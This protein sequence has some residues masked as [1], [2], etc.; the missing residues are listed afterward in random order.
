MKSCLLSISIL[1]L[2]A[3]P[4]SAKVWRGI[5]PL[6]STRAD[7]E[8]LFG[9]PADDE[10]PYMWVYDFP[11]ERALIYF[12]SG[13]PCEEGLAE[14]W[15]VPKDIVVQI[16]TMPRSLPKLSEMLTPGKEYQ[17]IRAVHTPTVYYVDSE[18]G[19]SFT[20]ADD[21]VQSITYGA[22]AKDK[23]LSCGEYKYA[24]PVAAGAKLSSI[25][26]YPFDDFGNIRFDDAKARLDNFVIQLFALKEEE[27]RWQGYII[28]YAGRRSYIGAAQYKANCF[29]NY[30]APE[31]YK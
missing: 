27:P 12:S 18:E 30:L 11:E 13:Q 29:K 9:H 1:L 7:V 19:L 21:L 14:G 8:R 23:G 5:E 17:R 22:A 2:A 31:F 4:I 24:A 15:K 3:T 10:S 28:V 16:Y 20:V 26:Q 25:E 6:H